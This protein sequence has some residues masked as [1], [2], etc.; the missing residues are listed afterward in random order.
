M[1]ATEL[2]TIEL[3]EEHLPSLRSSSSS[4]LSNGGPARDS[5]SSVVLPDW[6]DR[7]GATEAVEARVDLRKRYDQLKAGV[8]WL[9]EV[10][11]EQ[12]GKVE[13]Y[14]VDFD[15]LKNWLDKEKSS[16]DHLLPLAVALPDIE[17]Q[18]KEVQVHTMLKKKINVHLAFVLVCTKLCH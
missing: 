3:C 11:A 6:F 15:K 13:A 2:P 9:A 5:S 12:L 7:P 10:G 4:H 1:F 17:K 18:L 8:A 14:E 16:V